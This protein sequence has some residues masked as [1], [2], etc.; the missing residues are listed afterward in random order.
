MKVQTL[1]SI[2]IFSITTTSMVEASSQ[3]N[4]TE[5]ASLTHNVPTMTTYKNMT[6]SQLQVAAEKNGKTGKASFALS[7]ELMKRWTNS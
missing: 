6:T 2:I 7:Y 4:L 5:V 3:N 1:A